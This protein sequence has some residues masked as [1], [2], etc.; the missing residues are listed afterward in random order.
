MLT[1]RVTV[2]LTWLITWT[3]ERESDA[4]G[5]GRRPG[6]LN[7]APDTA[8]APDRVGRILVCLSMLCPAL[9]VAYTCGL[10]GHWLLLLMFILA[11]GVTASVLAVAMS[12]KDVARW[13]LAFLG[14]CLNVLCCGI[15]AYYAFN[16]D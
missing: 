5:S 2:R 1:L 15:V 12:G 7:Y 16:G 13:G 9:F 4:I 10:F 8:A 6:V 3:A 14:L 11:A